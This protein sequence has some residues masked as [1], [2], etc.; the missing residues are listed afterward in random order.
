MTN[1]VPLPPASDLQAWLAATIRVA[2][3][4][5]GLSQADLA[6]TVSITEK[7]LSRMLNGR[8][9]GSL[10]MWDRLLKAAKCWPLDVTR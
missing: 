6:V 10:T 9:E 2:L 1:L 7:H 5:D 3:R 4:N 8:Q